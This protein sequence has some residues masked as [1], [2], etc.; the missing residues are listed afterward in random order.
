MNQHKRIM[1]LTA[2]DGLNNARQED[3][4]DTSTRRDMMRRL[5]SLGLV[6]AGGTVLA[7]HEVDGKGK[8]KGKGK[9]KGKGKGKGKDHNKHNSDAVDNSNPAPP[10]GGNQNPP[11][12][13]GNNQTPP[14]DGNQTPPVEDETSATPLEDPA[15]E[16]EEQVEAAERGAETHAAASTT[17][18]TNVGLSIDKLGSYAKIRI[19]MTAQLTTLAQNEIRAGTA[20]YF[21]QVRLYE[22]DNSSWPWGDDTDDLVW[23]PLSSRAILAQ[24]VYSTAFSS[25]SILWNRLISFGREYYAEVRLYRRDGTG[26]RLVQTRKSIRRNI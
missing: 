18:I 23:G 10:A 13:G 26:T 16:E 4:L 17:S 9:S 25:S 6:A 19:S 11:P 2:L 15:L 8:G 3:S 7:A 24:N 12:Q 14:V 5:V 22:E 1:R 20:V 21:F